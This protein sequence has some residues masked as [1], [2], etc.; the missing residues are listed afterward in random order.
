MASRSI[1][2]ALVHKTRESD[3]GKNDTISM[4]SSS[5][6][7]K[8]S[9]H[10]HANKIHFHMKSFALSLAF[11]MRCA[12]TRGCPILC[13]GSGGTGFHGEL[14]PS[15]RRCRQMPGA[16]NPIDSSSQG[17]PECQPF[18]EAVSVDVCVDGKE[19]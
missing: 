2:A 17:S 15:G 1:L 14:E 12:T 10:S 11:I 6:N 4:R 7:A 3:F 9:F 8:I 13:C 5:S 19:K 18:Q 16:S